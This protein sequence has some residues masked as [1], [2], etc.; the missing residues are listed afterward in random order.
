MTILAL[1]ILAVLGEVI[2]T[3]LEHRCE[4][5]DVEITTGVGSK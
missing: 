3:I 4:S 5:R 1:G 2:A